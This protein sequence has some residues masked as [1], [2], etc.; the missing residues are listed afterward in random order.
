MFTR[1]LGALLGS[2]LLLAIAAAPATAQWENIETVEGA[3]GSDM[4]LTERPHSVAEELSVRALAIGRSDTTRWALSLIGASLDDTISVAFGDESL[5]VQDI[6]R[7]SGGVGPTK[8]FV[9]KEAFLTMA[10]TQTV[11]L[12]VGDVTVTL[13]EQLRQEM[14]EIFRRAS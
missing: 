8:V 1:V 13:P 2:V 9:S 14:E 7:P 10:E 5:P 12:R 4:T 3:Y 6:Q 11:T